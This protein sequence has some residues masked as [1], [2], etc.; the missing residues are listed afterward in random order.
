MTESIYNLKAFTEGDLFKV[1]LK[2]LWATT[3]ST[4]TFFHYGGVLNTMN[5][6]L[7]LCMDC[8]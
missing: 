8:L 4:T 7:I 1:A 3:Y 5:P 2:Y 6:P